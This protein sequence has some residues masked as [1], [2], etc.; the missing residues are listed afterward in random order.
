MY[1][2][3]ARPVQPN[4]ANHYFDLGLD[5]TATTRHIKLAYMR[6]AKIHHPDKQGTAEEVDTGEFRKAGTLFFAV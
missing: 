4:V 2:P 1:W 6:L 3:R 5:Q